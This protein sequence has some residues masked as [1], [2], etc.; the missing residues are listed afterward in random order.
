MI[1]GAEPIF[2]TV[3]TF[4][5]GPKQRT[6]QRLLICDKPRKLAEIHASIAGAPLADAPLYSAATAH[7]PHFLCSAL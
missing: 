2:T 3:F 6:L 1:E 7:I 4:E 5:V